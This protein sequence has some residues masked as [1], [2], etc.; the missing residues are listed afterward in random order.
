MTRT[1]SALVLL[2]ATASLARPQPTPADVVFVL[3]GHADTVDA[4]AVSP[5]GKLIATAS[6]DK[7]VKLWDAA[8]GKEIRTYAGDKGHTGQVLSV[9][10]SAK[11]DQIATGGADN[12]ALV[13]DVPVNFP[14]KTYATAAAAT[15]VAMA[16]D[17]KTFAVAAG[18]VVK[19]FPQGEEKGAIELKA[20]AVVGVA[21]NSNGQMIATVGKDNT[22]R[23]WNAADGK[24]T[25]AYG[26][27]AAELTGVAVN[28]NNQAAY[29]TSADGS[30]KFWTLPPAPPKLSNA[31]LAFSSG[32]ALSLEAAATKAGKVLPATPAKVI[33][34]AG[35]RGVAVS[36]G[37]ERV[38]TIGPG[39]TVASWNTGSGAKERDLEAGGDATA[40]AFTK[41]GTVAAVGG[42][43][44]SVRLYTVGDGKQVGTFAAGAG[45]VELA[46]HP[47]LSQLAGVLKNNTVVV[48]SVA[49]TPG[50]PLPPEFGKPVQSFPLPAPP[51]GVAFA[52]DG[53]VLAAC[54]DKQT[55][56]FRV[57]AADP[58]KSFTH[59]NLVD[60]V[61]FDDTGT[62]LATGGHDGFLRTFD[63]PKAAAL[64]AVQAHVQTAPTQQAH[65]VYAVAWTPD[66][67]Q[68][69]TASY[70]R[71]VK[72]WDAA[73]GTLVKEFKAAP[74]PA[75][76][77]APA[78]TMMKKDD[79]KDDKKDAKDEKKEVKKEEPPKGPFGHRDQV[80]AVAF[81]KDGKFFATGSSDRSVKLWDVGAGRVVRD[82]PNPDIK[83]TF[84]N[85]PAASHPGWVHTV[86]FTPDDKFI[87]SAGPA[88]R[89]KGYLAVWSVADGKR[90]FGAE[91][92]TGPLHGLAVTPDG[93]KLVIGCG[94]KS[95]TQPDAEAYIIK[96]K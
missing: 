73:Q 92:D 64:K 77:A 37:G 26:A 91:R 35:S 96:W 38:L 29:T 7:T 8:T 68:I 84:P 6:F 30:L 40:A 48:W 57:A 53:T 60:A 13:W 43:D 3:K 94:P 74:D 83:A 79:K 31:F 80:F 95:R 56:R 27:G 67:K 5:D 20:K 76:T 78:M 89:G 9:A 70:D 4:V 49:V 1:L 12:K 58:V 55:R 2:A 46:F 81:T 39:K 61:A 18:D 23:F 22:L 44:G 82:F 62:V 71:S 10:F 25:M 47:T 41:V 75:A 86:R 93:T 52:A 17:G 11:G 90:V 66:H 65:P 88:P 54:D 34:G 24:Q 50:Q 21:F 87:V 69:L 63:L 33:P 51:G 59:P 36:P 28:P 19:V 72:L 85:E 16:A 15:K 45:V 32:A 42:A 14:V